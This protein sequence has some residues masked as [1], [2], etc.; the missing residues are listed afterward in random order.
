MDSSS[1]IRLKSDYN[2][3]SYEISKFVDFSRNSWNKFS[4]VYSENTLN[5]LINGK[6]AGSLSNLT[7]SSAPTLISIG[8]R[9]D[10]SEKSETRIANFNISRI[11]KRY[12]KDIDGKLRDLQFFSKIPTYKDEY[13]SYNLEFDD[14]K[15]RYADFAEVTD[16]KGSLFRFE[17]DIYDNFSIIKNNELQKL[18]NKLI[19]NVKP[20]HVKSIV[21]YKNNR[22]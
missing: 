12:S 21:R 11:M 14:E 18:L 17:V 4:I 9:Y 19:N 22:C 13:T 2:S 10:N 16:E 20:A 1:N 15:F 7:I 8:C 6:E 3:Q 5:L